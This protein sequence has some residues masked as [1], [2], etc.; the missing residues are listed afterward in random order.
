[1]LEGVGQGL[2]HHS[3]DGGADALGDGPDVPHGP[4][5]HVEPAPAHPVEQSGQCGEA[6]LRL[7]R[8]GAVA[9]GTVVPQHPQHV[10]QLRHGVPPG[11]GDGVEGRLGPLGRGTHGHRSGLGLHDHQADGVGEDVVHLP[12]DPGPFTRGGLLGLDAVG[13]CRASV[14]RPNT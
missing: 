2:L 4:V 10:P 1:M 8:G 14:S 11:R 6:G 13:R 7:A 12:C 9:P 5:R 3:E